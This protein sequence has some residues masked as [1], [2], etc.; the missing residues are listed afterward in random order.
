MLD[1]ESYKRG[2]R[3]AKKAIAAGT[4]FWISTGERAFG[5]FIHSETGLPYLGL[6]GPPELENSNLSYAR[7]YNDEVLN[8]VKS[9]SIR[10]DFRPLLMTFNEVLASFEA[11]YIGTISDDSPRIEVSEADLILELKKRKTRHSRELTV[12]SFIRSGVE[13]GNNFE[14]YETPIRVA[15]GRDGQVLVMKTKRS[16]LTRDVVTTQ[17]LNFFLQGPGDDC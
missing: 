17:V 5:E 8:G 15:L 10:V 14:L 16:I 12:V 1:K 9:G 11:R 7:G 2:I 3:A 6:S 4:P 13:V